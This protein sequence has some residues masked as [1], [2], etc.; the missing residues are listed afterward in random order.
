MNR[1]LLF[2]FSLIFQTG[3]SQGIEGY[4]LDKG[5]PVPFAKVQI[6]ALDLNKLTDFDGY[7]SFINIASD[8]IEINISALNYNDTV[9]HLHAPYKVIHI[10]LTSVLQQLEEVVVSGTMKEVSK[11]ESIT[12]IEVLRPQFFK[13]NPTPSIYDAMQTVN[14]VRPQINCSVCNTG[15]IHINGLEGSYTMIL[16]DGMPIVSSLSTVYGLTGIPNSLVER[17]EIIK[18]PASALY[19]SE[20]IGGVINI[21]TKN[22]DKTPLLSIDVFTTSWLETSTDAAFKAKVSKAASVLTGIN[23]YN[24][25]NPIDNNGDGFTDVTQQHRISV[26]Q[27]WNFNRKSNKVFSLA[28]RYYYEDR[29]GGELNWNEQ[30]RG[31]DSIYG[32]SIFTNRWELLG[33]YQL[34][35]KEDIF[36]TTSFN[37]HQQN[38]VYGNVPYIADQ[39]IGFGQIYWT[40]KVNRHDLLTGT[41]VRYTRYD[42]NSPA[43]YDDQ[44]DVNLISKIIL[45]GI[46]LQDVISLNEKHKLLASFRYDYHSDHGSIYTPRIGYKGS[47]HKTDFRVN[48]GTGYRVVNI[49]TEDHAA[50]TGSRD[51]IVE[52][53]IKPETSYNINVNMNRSF[54]TKRRRYFNLDLS[55]FYTYFDNRII[56]DYDTDPNLI[57]YDNLQSYGINRGVSLNLSSTPFKQ[58]QIQL[59]ATLMEVLTFENQIKQQ[60]ILTENFTGTW[61]ITYKPSSSFSVDYTGNIYSPMRLPLL[62][63]ND[64]RPEYSPWWSIQNIQFTYKGLNNWEF[65][66]GVKNLLNWTPDKSSPFLIARTNDPFDKQVQFDTAGN[67]IPNSNN[68]YGLTFDPSYVYAP[69]Q[70][71]RGFIGVRYTLK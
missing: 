25:S 11:K 44:S 28:G 14:G 3:L 22:P 52:E 55:A 29:W 33:V 65:Y 50:L 60:Q 20:A 39:L 26:F 58:L 27:K 23:Y 56:A 59:G 63:Q 71:I 62:H 36:I 48:A 51:V 32:E 2:F 46:Y 47:V 61:T 41:A 16:I 9:I 18:G 17:I 70:G 7:F 35:L 1:I 43:T 21:I 12:N 66:G 24:Y 67:A 37:Q 49:F 53:G 68:P 69:T 42:D 15:D 5:S 4:V 31:G 54:L 38:S 34:P 45:P 57:I 64:P 8:S 30:F 40:K 10:E 13:K 6:K 19:G